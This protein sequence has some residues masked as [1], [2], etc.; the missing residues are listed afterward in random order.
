MLRCKQ[1]VRNTYVV[2]AFACELCCFPKCALLAALAV[3]VSTTTRRGSFPH[4]Q[5]KKKKKKTG[6]DTDGKRNRNPGLYARC[7]RFCSSSVLMKGW[8]TDLIAFLDFTKH[9][10][11]AVTKTVR[12]RQ[13]LCSIT[14]KSRPEMSLATIW[15]ECRPRC[16]R[17]GSQTPSAVIIV[18]CTIKKAEAKTLLKGALEY[19]MPV[20][21]VSV[22]CKTFR[23]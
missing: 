22:W 10:I 16:C 2:A 5:K 4:G 19:Y 12:T 17:A 11:F 23:C 8:L 13:L 21:V 6:G 18:S 20:K 3:L 1:Q 9:S 14:W 15:G 7:E